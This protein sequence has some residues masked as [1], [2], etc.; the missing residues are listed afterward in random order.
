VIAEPSSDGRQTTFTWL[1]FNPALA[2]PSPQSPSEERHIMTRKYLIV[3]LVTVGMLPASSIFSDQVSA[4]ACRLS[5]RT[6]GTINYFD[7]GH[8]Q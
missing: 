7:G 8:V 5:F 6:T 3:A 4:S 1:F 2:D